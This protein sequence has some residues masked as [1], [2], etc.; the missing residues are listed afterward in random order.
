MS[1]LAWYPLEKDYKNYGLG[2]AEF[3]LTSTTTLA[4]PTFGNGGKTSST[5]FTTNAPSTIDN[6][7]VSNVHTAGSISLNN[8]KNFSI[9]CWAKRT[10]NVS[11]PQWIFQVGGGDYTNNSTAACGIGVY[12]D[13][14]NNLYLNNNGGMGNGYINGM[15]LN[16]WYHIVLTLDESNTIYVYLNGVLK[17]TKNRVNP[18]VSPSGLVFGS[19]YA[20]SFYNFR[21]CIQ[22]ARFYDHVLSQ[23]EIHN[24]YNSLIV[25]YPFNDPEETGLTNLY[26]NYKNGWRDSLGGF[27][28]TA[29]EENGYKFTRYTFTYTGTGSSN[30]FWLAYPYFSFTAGKRYWYSCKVRVN[31][32][33]STTTLS[34]RAARIGNDYDAASKPVGIS[35]SNVGKGWYTIS[36]YQDLQATSTRSG[37]SNTTNP[38]IEF[39]TND[40]G[41]SGKVFSMSIDIR[42]VCVYECPYGSFVGYVDNTY[43]S[44]TICDVSGHKNN[45]TLVGTSIITSTTGLSGKMPINYSYW[46]GGNYARID[47]QAGKV[48]DEITVAVWAY[49]SD[50]YSEDFRLVSCTG[51]GGWNFEKTT[52]QQPVVRWIVYASGGYQIAPGVRDITAG[53]H[54][55][56]GTWDGKQAKFYIDGV[57]RSSSTAL[58]TKTP[59]TYHTGNYVIIGAEAGTSNTAAGSTSSEFLNDLRIYASALSADDVRQLYSVRGKIDNLGNVYDFGYSYDNANP[60]PKFTANGRCI[61]GQH[62]EIDYPYPYGTNSALRV[63]PDGSIWMKIFHHNNPASKLFAQTDPFTTRFVKDDDR[64]ADFSI[65]NQLT[66]FELMGIICATSGGTTYKYRWIQPVNPLTATWAQVAAANITKNTTSGY[67]NTNWGGLWKKNG[68]T[69]LCQNDGNSEGDWWGAVGAWNQHAGGI[70]GLNLNVVTTGYEDLYVRID[71]GRLKR[72]SKINANIGKGGLRGS[73][74]TANNFYEI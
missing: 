57:L 69:Y 13:A 65:F 62:K 36:T 27:T 32:M 46:T 55:F 49:R 59:I 70:P 18:L 73:F 4:T 54:H 53:W 72:P 37:T 42:D 35:S 30:W 3:N 40:I 63:E 10:M 34:F 26:Q 6:T 48:T 2:G 64:W 19:L 17:L 23:E 47:Y 28:A 1:L 56:V 20:T 39:Y 8:G 5:C 21:G 16:Q 31:S 43:M 9:A 74:I 60:N 14:A 44:R 29:M 67:T 24:I 38:R 41:A 7:K 66:S 58:S 61:A 33:A 22:D 25:H 11:G 12:V 68:S 45:G 52:G 15:E 51:A 50:W 71:G